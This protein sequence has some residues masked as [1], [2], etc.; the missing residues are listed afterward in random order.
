MGLDILQIG[1]LT[2]KMSGKRGQF[3][4]KQLNGEEHSVGTQL[5]ISGKPL[6]AWRDSVSSV[7][8]PHVTQS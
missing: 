7:A 8:D 6:P 1:K 3:P 4:L 5:L 2:P